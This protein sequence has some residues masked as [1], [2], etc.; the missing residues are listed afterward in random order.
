MFKRN[1][2]FQPGAIVTTMRE[3]FFS[4]LLNMGN[5]IFSVQK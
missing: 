5:I 2:G 4:F 3:F 1:L